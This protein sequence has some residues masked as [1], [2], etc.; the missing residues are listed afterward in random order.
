M[1][2]VGE[3]IGQT[4]TYNQ[5]ENQIPST[6]ANHMNRDQKYNVVGKKNLK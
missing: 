2:T 5:K 3:S 6:T 1:Y 4:C